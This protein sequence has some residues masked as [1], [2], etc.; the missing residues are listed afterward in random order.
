MELKIFTR[1]DI[2]FPASAACER[3]FSETGVIF[4]PKGE[5]VGDG[6]FDNQSLSRVLQVF[7]Q[8]ILDN[9]YG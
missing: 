1:M 5:C 2:A 7:V 8:G 4:T 6:N 9:H 3:L